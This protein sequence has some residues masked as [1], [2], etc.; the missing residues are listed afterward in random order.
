MECRAA[1]GHSAQHGG[2]CWATVACAMTNGPVTCAAGS[3]RQ[4][5]PVRRHPR[6]GSPHRQSFRVTATPRRRT[7]TTALSRRR[8]RHRHRGRQDFCRG[9][10]DNSCSLH[11]ARRCRRRPVAARACGRRTDA[12]GTSVDDTQAVLP[13]G[14]PD[15]LWH[16]AG[17]IPGRSRSP[18]GRT[19]TPGTGRRSSAPSPTPDGCHPTIVQ[20]VEET[21][22]SCANRQGLPPPLPRP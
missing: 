13:A 1:G 11:R 20:L 7:P 14:I 8:R 4:R 22:R 10:R 5:R 6:I 2:R 16:E 9:C 18:P 3:D 21:T 15:K 12:G 17:G 19:G